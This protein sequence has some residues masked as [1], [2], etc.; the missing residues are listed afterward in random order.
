MEIDD[1]QTEEK[2]EKQLCLSG[3]LAIA[4]GRSCSVRSFPHSADTANELGTPMD[5][6]EIGGAEANSRSL[7]PRGG[8]LE[9]VSD[10]P[11]V[12][13]GKREVLDDEA[14]VSFI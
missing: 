8:E 3:E 12:P 1:V 13:F 11:L 5:I 7:S 9:V 4:E 14:E 2:S 10:E 6:D